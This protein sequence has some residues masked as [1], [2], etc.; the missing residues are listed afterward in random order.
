[1]RKMMATLMGSGGAIAIGLVLM[2]A[3]TQAVLDGITQGSGTIGAGATLEAEAVMIYD[4][5]PVGIFAVQ[6]P[7]APRD[8]AAHVR[9]LDP[10]GSVIFSGDVTEGSIEGRFDVTVD[11]AYTLIVDSMDDSQ[12][13]AFGAIGPLPDT[14]SRALAFIPFYVLLSGIMGMAGLGVYWVTG[15]RRRG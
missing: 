4:T 14:W 1:M 6:V 13:I 8:G 11:G 15:M 3:G 5:E 7:D 10:L 2:V 12:L 9:I